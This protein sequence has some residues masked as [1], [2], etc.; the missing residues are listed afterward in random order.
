MRI[1]PP[2]H[3]RDTPLKEGNKKQITFKIPLLYKE[4]WQATPDGVV[5]FWYVNLSLNII[6][7]LGIFYMLIKNITIIGLGL[8]GGSVG[9]AVKKYAPHIHVTGFDTNL[10]S[11][12][13]ALELGFI[14]TQYN[15]VNDAVKNA[16]MVIIATPLGVFG[17]VASAIIPNMKK[18][19]ILT[20]TGSVKGAVIDM[21][22]PLLSLNPHIHFVPA[23]PIAGT[24][25]SGVDAGFADLFQNRMLVITPLDDTNPQAIKIVTDF[26]DLLGARSQ[27]MTPQHHDM[28]FAIV[29]HIPHL[30]AYNIVGTANHLETVSEQEVI[31]YA[32]SGFRDF[33]RLASSD[34]V[35]WRDV[36]L[37]NRDA[38]L[39]MLG[40][41][42][43][44]LS[45]V[46]RAIRYKDGDALEALFTKT[47]D[48]R[49]KI[50]EAGQ[51][52]AK[53]NFGRNIE[54]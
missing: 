27:T 2:R 47:R 16:D 51:E 46:Q 20:D 26:W 33:T 4:G 11:V 49:K 28:V 31:R 6:I 43:E 24:E 17:C 53:E 30:I 14:D 35:V 32:A 5:I 38:V 45:D 44:D 52:S 21:I 50:I 37:N 36:F 10:S 12:K 54:N 15:T 19:A 23:H 1:K 3:L 22:T 18:N 40:R 7:E 42:I 39:E 9:R 8:L 48:I 25:K 29:S 41:F 34:P 13:R